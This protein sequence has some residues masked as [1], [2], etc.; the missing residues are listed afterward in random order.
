LYEAEDQTSGMLWAFRFRE[1]QAVP[2]TTPEAPD[3]AKGEWTWA[4][5]PLGDRRARDTLGSGLLPPE[6]HEFLEAREER[7]QFHGRGAWTWGMLP[8]LERDLA[9]MSLDPGRLFFAM[10]EQQLVTARLHALRVVDDV[11][12]QCEQDLRLDSPVQAV[13]ALIE[14]Y[15]EVVEERLEALAERLDAVEDQVLGAPD[16]LDGRQL[17]PFRRELAQ[18]RREIQ[19]LRSAM[20]RG[21]GG[22]GSRQANP[23]GAD[24]APLLGFIEDL[25]SE[26][27][28]LQERARLLHEEID[29]LITS[30]TNRS[31]R[32]LTIIS[33]LLIPPT[34]IV[35]AF[36]MNLGGIP[37]S[38]SNAGF[39]WAAV[40]CLATVAGA[41]LLLRRLRM[42]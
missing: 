16:E 9:G 8:D 35:G 37:F 15:T 31:M 22:R 39:A 40:V 6:I 41:V 2:L 4:H 13:A 28:G 23:L 14:H 38:H 1:G 34:L 17:G 19:S 18:H 26:A 7:V 29:T 5:F 36:G 20:V 10:D 33:T 21:R 42:L 27:A 12:R 11:R 24:L 3:L 25:D 30:A 32:A